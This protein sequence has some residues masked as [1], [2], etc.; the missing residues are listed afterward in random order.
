M[1][2]KSFTKACMDFF[3]KLPNQT[4]QN[5]AI[6]IKTALVADRPGWEKLFAEIGVELE[7]AM[8]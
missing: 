1:E 8:K 6:E 4:T 3:G 7:P 5:F 2:R